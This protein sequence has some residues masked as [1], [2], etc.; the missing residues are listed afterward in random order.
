MGHRVGVAGAENDPLDDLRKLARY[1]VDSH[2]VGSPE[3]CIERV[4]Q[5]QNDVGVNYIVLNMRYGGM[6]ND[7]HLLG[8]VAELCEKPIVV[9][10]LLFP[11]AGLDVAGYAV[12]LGP[13]RELLFICAAFSEFVS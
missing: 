12:E 8:I 3:T 9:I 1:P 4:R 5:Y 7:L 6:P 2:I 10:R 13:R 11:A